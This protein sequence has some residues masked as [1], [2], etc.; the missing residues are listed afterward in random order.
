MVNKTDELQIPKLGAN[1]KGSVA[2][3]QNEQVQDDKNKI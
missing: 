1:R 2:R 3:K